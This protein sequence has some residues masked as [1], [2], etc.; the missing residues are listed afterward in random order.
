ML[1]L[2]RILKKRMLTWVVKK[3]KMLIKLINKNNFYLLIL[4]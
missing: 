1:I 4:I 3:Y 2:T